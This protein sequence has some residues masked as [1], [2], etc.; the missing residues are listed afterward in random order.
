[1][2]KKT[3]A[4]IAVGI[5][6]AFVFASA[7]CVSKKRLRTVEQEHAEQMAQANARI[8]ELVEAKDTLD[9]DLTKTRANLAGAQSENK[10]LM[11]KAASLKDQ[12]AALESQKAELDQALAAGK[13]TEASY[14]KK[15]RGLNG[16]IAGLRKDVAEMESQI[17]AKDEM[18]ASLR[19]SEAKLTAASEDQGRQITALMSD[20]DNLTA[21]L[22]K[23]IAGKKSITL[24]LGILLAL[25]VIL[26][27][28]GFARGR[29]T[30]SP[31]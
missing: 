12:L 21:E 28:I 27:I 15:V 3:L 18:I 13:E 22:D 10:E 25:A 24:I 23:T 20:K 26:A 16:L 7:G 9:Q 14:Q 19:D 29:K 31:A 6:V 2:S 17:A 5:A 4:V 30:A 1:M 8:D 11:A